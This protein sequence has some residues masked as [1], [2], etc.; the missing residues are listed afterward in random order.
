MPLFALTIALIAQT[1]PADI[2]FQQG[3][4][5]EAKALYAREPKSFRTISQLGYIAMLSNRFADAERHLGA[6][7]KMKPGDANAKLMLAETYYR[8]DKFLKAAPLLK[9]L[10]KYGDKIRQTTYASLSY[11][12]LASFKG[13]TPYEFHGKGQ[14]TSIK[15]ITLEPL[16]LLHVK[17]N[18][19]PLTFF[20]DTGAAEVTLDYGAAKRLKVPILGTEVGTFSGGKTMKAYHG[21]IN[22][23]NVGEWELRNL[24]IQSL[25]LQPIAKALGRPIDGIVGTMLF[26]HF[27]TTLD[28]PNSRLVFTRQTPAN[29]ARALAPKPG[30]VK[31]PIWL[32]GDHFAVT[33]G[34]LNGRRP[35]QM[36]VDTGYIGG[37]FK[38]APSVIKSAGITLDTAKA[39]EGQG[40]GGGYTTTPFT[41]DSLKVGPVQV[42]NSTGTFEGVFPWEHTYGFLL[43]G[44][45][46]ADFFKPYAVTFDYEGM[47]LL[48]R[49]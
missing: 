2:A 3:N 7:L 17:V 22:S 35:V 16:P 42:N 47:K 26:Y 34:S 11:K 28:Y 37:M 12:K 8:Q 30:D 13:L 14:S 10:S 45:I 31:L 49:K 41:L 39:S 43:A 9:N 38:A 46:G 27:L 18:G 44:M 32:A 29:R 4:F 24:P 23:L 6:A 19:K 21:R 36:F 33:P 1:S 15:L 5:N 40:A 25:D 48:I 20:I